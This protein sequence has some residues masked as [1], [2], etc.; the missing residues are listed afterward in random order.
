MAITQIRKISSWTLL[1]LIAISAIVLAVFY[2]GGWHMDGEKKVYEQTG[3][4][5]GWTYI[6]FCAVIV[7]TLFFALTALA[8]GFKNNPKKA[9]GSLLSVVAL[10]A[11]V[12]I[13][14]AIGSTEELTTLNVDSQKYN[15]PSWLKLSDMWLYTT[16]VLGFCTVA[17]VVWGSIRKSIKR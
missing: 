15:T 6:L 4:L 7:I 11:L 9:M 16:Y 8:R 5:L 12:V 3:L 10:V 2:F 14:Y 13:S 17:A 1:I